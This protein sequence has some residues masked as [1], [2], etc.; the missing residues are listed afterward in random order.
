MAAV[1]VTNLQDLRPGRWGIP[2]PEMPAEGTEIPEPDLILVPCVAATERGTR[3]GHGGGYYDRFLAEHPGERA[4]LCFR[5]CLR[6]EL[7]AEETDLKMD[8]VI[9]EEGLTGRGQSE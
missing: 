4:A 3:L 9:H 2:E 8:R 5:A 1:P 7:P 6:E